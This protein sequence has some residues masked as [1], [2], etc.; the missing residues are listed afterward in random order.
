[1]S[2][3]GSRAGAVGG[4]LVQG[5]FGKSSAK[6]QMDFQKEESD[7]SYQRAV[8]D[9]KKAGLNPALAYSQGGASTP[10]GAKA[11]I[12]NPSANFTKIAQ[13][14]QLKQ[15]TA[16][17]K[18]QELLTAVQAKRTAELLPYEKTKMTA[19]ANS[20]MY[21][22][23]TTTATKIGDFIDGNKTSAKDIVQSYKIKP[24]KSKKA[25]KAWSDYR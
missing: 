9:M 4:S 16:T 8:V 1:M 23:G 11:Q 14:E 7:T 25:K 17:A 15:Q 5:L 6:D 12:D 10:T 19:E 22:L 13:I 2:I 21:R 3:W 24:N 18:A 20:S